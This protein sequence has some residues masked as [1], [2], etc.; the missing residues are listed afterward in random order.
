MKHILLGGEVVMEVVLMA[1]PQNLSPLAVMVSHLAWN[2]VIA[3]TVKLSML[4][5]PTPI[6]PPCRY[7]LIPLLVSIRTEYNILRV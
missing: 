3:G 6:S 5:I 7:K 1:E 2:L 4:E